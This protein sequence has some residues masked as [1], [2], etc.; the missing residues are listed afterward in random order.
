MCATKEGKYIRHKWLH[1]N[2][3]GNALRPLRDGTLLL[4]LL[5]LA[6]VVI[7]EAGARH[8]HEAQAGPRYWLESGV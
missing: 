1:Q 4:L 3:K 5:L 6:L 7:G 2:R 8:R